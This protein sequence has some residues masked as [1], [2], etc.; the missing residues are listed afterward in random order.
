MAIKNRGDLMACTSVVGDE[1]TAR[2]GDGPV[3]GKMTAYIVE[4]SCRT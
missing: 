3:T 2:L 1:M 4:A